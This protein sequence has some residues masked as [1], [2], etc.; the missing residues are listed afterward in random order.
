MRSECQNAVEV[1][2]VCTEEDRKGHMEKEEEEEI[3]GVRVGGNPQ[4]RLSTFF[5]SFFPLGMFVF[6]I[7]L[8]GV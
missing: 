8:I 1:D 4:I 2:V 3:C 6:G 5:F 7:C